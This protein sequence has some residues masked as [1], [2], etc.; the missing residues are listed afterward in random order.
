M[1]EKG[2]AK[3]G[4]ELFVKQTCIPCHTIAKNEPVKGP[5]LGD[6]AGRYTRAELIESILKPSAKI[7]QGFETQ[8]FKMKNGQRHDGFIVHEGGDEIELRNATGAT[9]IK[10]AEIEKR[11]KLETSIM[12][13]G[14]ANNLSTQELASLLAYLESLKNQ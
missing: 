3:P 7:A 5:F 13:D 2:D 14:I 1:K 9:V 4:A 10:T 11:S 8:L 6:I 12:P